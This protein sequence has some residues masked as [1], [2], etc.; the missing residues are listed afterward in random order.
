MPS[1]KNPGFLTPRAGQVPA[2]TVPSAG[3]IQPN[4]DIEPLKAHLQD[5]SRAHMASAIGIVDAGGFFATDEVEDALQ[6]IG[7]GSASGA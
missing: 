7:G 2:K 5:P 6:E 3:L 4:R 1:V